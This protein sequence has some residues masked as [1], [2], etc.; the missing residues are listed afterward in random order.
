MAARS[1]YLWISPAPDLS[2]FRNKVSNL[3]PSPVWVLEMLIKLFVNV[4]DC[5]STLYNVRAVTV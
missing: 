2:Y 1:I 5:T 4:V 3:G